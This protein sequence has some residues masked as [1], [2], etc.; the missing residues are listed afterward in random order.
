MIRILS[1]AGLFIATIQGA[2]PVS[3]W[4]VHIRSGYDSNVLRL[5]FV[6]QED[7]A[8]DRDLLGRMETFDSAFLRVG[9]SVDFL[10]R[11]QKENQI[12]RQK[13][14]LNAT[15]YLQSPDRKYLSGGWSLD[16]SW[17]PYRHLKLK[18]SL[19][20]RYYLRDYL[21]RDV[22]ADQ[23][24]ACYFTD[25]D[26]QLALSLPV[27]WRTWFQ[28]DVGQLQRYYPDPFAEFSLDIRYLGIQLSRDFSRKLRLS[29]YIRFNWANNITFQQTAR[30][31]DLDRSYNSMDMEVP[32]RLRLKRSVI[33]EIG[34]SQ[35]TE[36]RYYEAENFQDPLHAG[37]SH[38]DTQWNTWLKGHLADNLTIKLNLRYR[39]RKTDSE[40][41]WVRDLKS[42]HQFQTWIE[43]TRDFEPGWN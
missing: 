35:K 3:S 38:V 40:F 29:T 10:R 23:Q 39:I 4:D 16:Y 7:A 5:S 24:A 18:M 41:S 32:L 2:I 34:F 19:L 14:S 28:I 33:R 22:S 31:S 27:A 13:V 25:L 15:S 20:N 36:W 6:D 8:I 17:G 42:F 1:I 26:H 21:N 12:L 30:A 43:I 11:F 37:R 9:G